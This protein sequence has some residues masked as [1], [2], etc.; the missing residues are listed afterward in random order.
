MYICIYTKS[1]EG[2][3]HMCPRSFATTTSPASPAPFQTTCGDLGLEPQYH[4]VDDDLVMHR[5]RLDFGVSKVEERAM[6]QQQEE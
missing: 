2:D 6:I 3:C 5:Q 1:Y 4:L